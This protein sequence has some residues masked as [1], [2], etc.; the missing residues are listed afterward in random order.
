MDKMK[1]SE[2]GYLNP[3]MM[4]DNPLHIESL[5]KMTTK[6]LCNELCKRDGVTEI[7]TTSTQSAFIYTQDSNSTEVKNPINP[8]GAARI[9]V[10]RE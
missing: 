5:S 7:K 10:V 9:L 1:L 6:E 8:R 2:N 4:S 3:E